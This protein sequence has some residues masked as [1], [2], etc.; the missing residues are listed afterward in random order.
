MLV[1]ET[2]PGRNISQ[3]MF[4]IYTTTAFQCPY[5]ERAK[6]TLRRLGHSYT[7]LD[8]SQ[9]GVA[10]ALLTRMPTAK[11]IPQIWLGNE[12]IGGSDELH[13]LISAGVL[14]MMLAEYKSG[15]AMQV[16]VDE[17]QELDLGYGDTVA[18]TT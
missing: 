5:C 14:D 18:A 6:A 2:R 13:R 7:E 11:T 16:L 8:V 3:S 4:T 17:A 12:Y 1:L 9:P 15:E 10:S